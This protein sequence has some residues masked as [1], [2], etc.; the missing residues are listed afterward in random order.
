MIYHCLKD[1]F[2]LGVIG[3]ILRYY[4]KQKKRKN[5]LIELKHKF[6]LINNCYKNKTYFRAHLSY[7]FDDI[8][9]TALFDNGFKNLI[10]KYCEDNFVKIMLHQNKNTRIQ[11]FLLKYQKNY[12]IEQIINSCSYTMAKYLCE[13][14]KILSVNGRS[15]HI[16]TQKHIKYVLDNYDKLFKEYNICFC[17]KRLSGKKHFESNCHKTVK[18]TIL[19]KLCKT[20]SD[21]LRYKQIIMNVEDL[22]YECVYHRDWNHSIK[23]KDYKCMMIP[24]FITK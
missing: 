5:K 9:I 8:D 21:E 17:S 20:R 10:K 24:Y 1:V 16:R 7:N 22:V 19:E 4:S 15:K 3:I 23:N 2:P 12:N 11:G 18:K 6:E 14:R 13:C